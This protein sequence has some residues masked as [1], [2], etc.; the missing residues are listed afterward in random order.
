MHNVHLTV[1]DGAMDLIERIADKLSIKEDKVG[2]T[3]SS[4]LLLLDYMLERSKSD[5]TVTK[6]LYEDSKLL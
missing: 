3:I 6:W 4:S 1:S 2:K 5:P